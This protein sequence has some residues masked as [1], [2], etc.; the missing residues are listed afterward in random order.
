MLDSG[1]FGLRL[2]ALAPVLLV[3]SALRAQDDIAAPAPDAQ[4]EVAAEP[5]A[6]AH[7][8][9]RATEE[10]DAAAA[11]ANFD[12]T[13]HDCVR[14]SNIKRVK[15]IDDRTLL[16]FM[17]GRDVVYRNYLD[18]VCPGL[19]RE[20]RIGYQTSTSMLCDFDLITVLEEYGTGLKPGFTCSLS[21]FVPI[22]AEEAEEYLVAKEDLGRKRRAIESQP[23]ELPPSEDAPEA[24]PEQ[25]SEP[26]E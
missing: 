21:D 1:R 7:G 19:E 16:F 10:D 8:A 4:D 18:R 20:N 14:V 5:S 9:T 3:A 13:P 24:A 6:I 22:T 23:A 17:R 26:R 12:R 25:P 11:D 15:A 2:L